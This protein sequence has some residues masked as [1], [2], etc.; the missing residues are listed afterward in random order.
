[1]KAFAIELENRPGT[2][3][4]VLEA[5][6]QRGINITS[7]GGTSAGGKGALAL[8]TNDES[9]TRSALAAAGIEAREFDVVG[10]T[11][12]HEPGTLAT[13]TRRLA[14]AGVNLELLLPTDVSGS[15]VSVAIGVDKLDAARE[16]LGELVTA[17]A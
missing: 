3:A 7:V 8:L 13:A 9:G 11:L 1:M 14:D 5:I 6:A 10:V 2:V 17:S 16:A 4:E 15:D 12:P